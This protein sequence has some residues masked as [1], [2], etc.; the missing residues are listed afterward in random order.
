MDV[1]RAKTSGSLD[2]IGSS[3]LTYCDYRDSSSFTLLVTKYS[4]FFM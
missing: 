2:V 1:G 3:P 4:N